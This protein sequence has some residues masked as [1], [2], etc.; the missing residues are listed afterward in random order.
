MTDPSCDSSSTAYRS[1]RKV[2]PAR[3]RFPR[4]SSRSAATPCGASTSRERS[5]MSG[6][7]ARLSLPPRCRVTWRP[8]SPLAATRRHPVRPAWSWHATV[9]SQTSISLGWNASTDNVGI[10]GYDIVNGAS[11]VGQAVGQTST[12][13]GLACWDDVHAR[14]R[15]VRRGRE[16]FRHLDDLSVDERLRRH[17]GAHHAHRP[18]GDELGPD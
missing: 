6:S 5:T 7:T 9:F 3:C 15:C 4:S 12:V 13:S 18:R 8:A 1:R 11:I 17:P 14:R 10:T 16:P 2:S